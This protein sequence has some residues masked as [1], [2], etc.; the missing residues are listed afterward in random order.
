ML[1]SL[2][3]VPDSMMIGMTSSST[4]MPSWPELRAK[5]A[6]T[7]PSPAFVKAYGAVSSRNRGRLPRIGTP[8][9]GCITAGSATAVPATVTNIIA[10][11]FAN[12][13]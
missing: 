9:I 2:T 1:S 8:K 6:E 12:I 3:H 11:T 10:S 5:V 4:I 13:T 7:S